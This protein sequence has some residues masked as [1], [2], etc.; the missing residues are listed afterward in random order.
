MVL[1]VAVL[2][3]IPGQEP[4]FENAFAKASSIIEGIPGYESHQLQ[5]CIEKESRYVLLVNWRTL[6]DHTIGFR[7]S[8]Q[9][10]TWKEL[11]HHFYDPF[12]VVQHYRLVGESVG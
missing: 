12:P 1:E 7:E 9:Y 11:L 10:Q 8:G 5:R 2:D 3:V 6:E 4:A